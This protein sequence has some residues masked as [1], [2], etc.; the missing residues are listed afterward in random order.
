MV[1]K[2]LQKVSGGREL[3]IT[4]KVHLMYAKL[5]GL[6]EVLGRDIVD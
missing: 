4:T 6:I 5:K 2:F 3:A 1:L